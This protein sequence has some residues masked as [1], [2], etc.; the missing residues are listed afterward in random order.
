MSWKKTKAPLLLVSAL[1]LV[2]AAATHSNVAG[3][4]S[5]VFFSRP[6]EEE[7]VGLDGSLAVSP[8]CQDNRYLSNCALKS[9]SPATGRATPGQSYT[10]RGCQKYYQ[11]RQGHQ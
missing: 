8:Y 1:L 5:N 6:Y 2:T 11:C 9:D 4:Y 10:G 7:I 3:D